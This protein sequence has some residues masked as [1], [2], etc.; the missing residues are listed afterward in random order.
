MDEMLVDA[1]GLMKLR[2]LTALC[3]VA[4]LTI[5]GGIAYKYLRTTQI[6][7]NDAAALLAA[8]QTKNSDLLKQ[9]GDI[10]I[11]LSATR[12]MYFDAIAFA[13]GIAGAVKLAEN[14]LVVSQQAKSYNPVGHYLGYGADVLVDSEAIKLDPDGYPTVKYGETYHYNPVTMAQ[15]ALSEYSRDGGPSDKFVQSADFLLGMMSPDGSFRYDFPFEQYATGK[16]YQ[17]G[18]I[19]GMAQGQALS[20]FARAYHVTKDEKYKVA[21]AKAL[22]FMLLDESKGG[23]LTTLEKF[24]P[25]P[26]SAPFI[27]EYPQD[28]PVYTLNGYMFSLLGLYD[29]AAVTKDANLHDFAD[30]S[31]ET[32]KILLPYYDMGSISAYDLSFITVPVSRRETRSRPEIDP[33][34]HRVHIELLWA[35]HNLTSDPALKEVALRWTSYVDTKD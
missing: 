6:N 11:W 1:G 14:G 4:L 31:L 29:W 8:E 2:L 15:F 5:G 20:V 30:K 26:S 9:L 23:P 32:L 3:G 17:P 21:G 22:A 25:E 35:L 33:S 7:E 13:P 19:S 28:P 16:M 18:W 12:K 34:Y 10:D 27:M 24:P